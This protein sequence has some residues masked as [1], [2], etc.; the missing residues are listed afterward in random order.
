VAPFGTDPLECLSAATYL[1]EC[2]FVSNREP[3]PVE[4][5]Y[6][7]LAGAADQIWTLDLDARVCPYMPICDPIVGGLIVR[8]DTSHLTTRFAIT[9]EEPVE[10]FLDDNLILG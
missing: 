7:R 5:I 8:R 4:Q 10:R 1:D 3:T 2:R 6:R 9:L